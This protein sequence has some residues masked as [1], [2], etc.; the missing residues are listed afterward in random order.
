MPM[1]ITCL[2]YNFVFIAIS[3]Y[4]CLLILYFNTYPNLKYIFKMKYHCIFFF[5]F[6]PWSVAMLKHRLGQIPLYLS[7]FKLGIY[8]F[9]RSLL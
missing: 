3:Y 6:S 4:N 7:L 9:H 8:L 2:H 1:H 5:C